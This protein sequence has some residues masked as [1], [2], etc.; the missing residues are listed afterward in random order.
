VSNRKFENGDRVIGCE[1]SS[2]SFRGRTG[3]VMNF[4]GRGGYGVKFDDTGVTEYLNSNWL[5]HEAQ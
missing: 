3:I 1:E 4:S 2:A 5:Q